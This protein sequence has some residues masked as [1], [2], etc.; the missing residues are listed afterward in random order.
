LPHIVDLFE[1]YPPEALEYALNLHLQLSA[2]EK[3]NVLTLLAKTG[4]HDSRVIKILNDAVNSDRPGD[5]VNGTVALWIAIQDYEVV[6][7]LYFARLADAKAI[8]ESDD[9]ESSPAVSSPSRDTNSNSIITLGS[10]GVAWMFHTHLHERPFRFMVALKS[11]AKS[12][13]VKVRRQLANYIL[14][15]LEYAIASDND[16][17]PFEIPDCNYGAVSE[18]AK[19]LTDDLDQRV[20]SDARAV[21]LVIEKLEQNV[22]RRK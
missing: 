7:P 16:G 6:L 8:R 20:V 12:T 1:T 21:L 4:S 14:A 2:V 17:H 3:S 13:D 19:T 5:R 22:N 9:G 11:F 18:L 15:S 10:M